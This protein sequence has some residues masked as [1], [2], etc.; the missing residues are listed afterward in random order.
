MWCCADVAERDVEVAEQARRIR[1]MSDA[2]G[3]FHP[4]EIIDEIAARFRRARDQHAD[5]G[6]T[7]SAAIFSE[8]VT[9]M[10]RHGAA[11]RKFADAQP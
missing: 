8:M 7:R 3:F 10:D 11:L 2:Y 4:A 5:A 1:L 9:W 6:R